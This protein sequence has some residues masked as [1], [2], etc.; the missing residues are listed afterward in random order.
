MTFLPRQAGLDEVLI[1]VAAAG[2]NNT[3]INTRTAW[4][5]KSVKGETNAGG[6][7]GFEDADAADGS[8]TGAK[9]NFPLIQG[10]DCCGYIVAVG[11]GVDPARRG[12]RVLVRNLL[13]SYVDYRG[14]ECWTFG[15]G[16]RRR[17]CSICQ[18][19]GGRDRSSGLRLERRGARI[20]S[21]RLFH[22][23]S[24]VT[25]GKGRS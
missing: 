12:E 16:M 5:S 13:R 23:R 3:D 14:F 7:S 8:W 11:E 22:R 2:I 1:R 21:M 4:Y 15:L 20:D 24:H 6:A 25:S 18:G 17:L 19:A 10:G 9:L